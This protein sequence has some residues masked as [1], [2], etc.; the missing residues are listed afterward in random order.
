M[1]RDLA[2]M[3]VCPDDKSPL[4]LVVERASGDDIVDGALACPQCGVSYPIRNSIPNLL[5]A[6]FSS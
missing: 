1:R 5:P 3:L 2:E 6:G 4:R